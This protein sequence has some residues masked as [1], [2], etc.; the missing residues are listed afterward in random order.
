MSILNTDRIDCEV[1]Y[2]AD[3]NLGFLEL[4]M[5]LFRFDCDG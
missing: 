2:E 4:Q 5:S 3:T 1:F